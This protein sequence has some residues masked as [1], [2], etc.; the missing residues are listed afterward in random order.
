MFSTD[1]SLLDTDYDHIEDWRE[2]HDEDGIVNLEEQRNI[3]TLVDAAARG[4][5][6]KVRSLITGGVELD[7]V[8]P[9][10]EE[11]APIRAAA[12]NSIDIAK[13]LIQA[14]ADVNIKT[15]NRRTALT[16]SK[17]QGHIEIV[18]LLTEAGAGE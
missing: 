10:W 12:N 15:S 16:V 8:D 13:L 2:D 14:G 18:K 4:D 6:R 1:P 9:F 11:T 3:E 17:R 7:A 5:K